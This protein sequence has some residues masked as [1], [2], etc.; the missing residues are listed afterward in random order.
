MLYGSKLVLLNVNHSESLR[1][2]GENTSQ[3]FSTFVE[4]IFWQM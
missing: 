2:I 1:F 3:H 4:P